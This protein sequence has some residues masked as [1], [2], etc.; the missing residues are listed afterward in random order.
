V[1]RAPEVSPVE[2]TPGVNLVGF[3]EGELGLGEVARKLGRALNH[4]GIPFAALPYRRTPSRQ[5]HSVDL[6]LASEARFDT[7]LVCLNADYLHAFLDDVGADFFAGRYSIGVWFWE[8]SVFAASNFGGLRFLDE[9]WVA[10][11]YVRRAVAAAADVPVHVVPLPVEAPPVPTRTRAELGLPQGFM[12]LFL[13]DFVSAERKNPLAVVEAFTRAFEP[14]EGPVLVLKSINGRERKPRQLEA[15]T[16]A[17]GDRGDID[18]VDAYFTAAERDAA[19]AS[20]DC[21]V[22]LHRSEGFGRTLAEAM[23]FGK[24]AIATAYSGNLEFMD[25]DNAYLVP[26]RLVPIPEGWWAY[27]PGAEWAEPDVG[28][29]AALMRRVYEN[30]AEAAGRGERARDEILRELSLDRTAAF[31]AR[32]LDDVQSRRIPVAGAPAHDVRSPILRASAELSKGVGSGL[33]AQRRS[34]PTGLARRLLRRL[35]WPEL[36]RAHEVDTAM[37]DALRALERSRSDDLERL[38]RLEASV[39]EGRDDR[40]DARGDVRAS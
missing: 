21:Y 19:V 1:S 8:S 7:N 32:R 14:G 16:A 5:E 34:G 35:L 25:D 37:L 38:S 11:E 15:V 29:A 26:Y 6:E 10:S 39:L 13:F 36:T 18:V 2:A 22:S 30:R 9:I 31:V 12:F 24:P 20:C 40:A 27:A 4:A 17:V 28:A 23:A 33:G 3:L